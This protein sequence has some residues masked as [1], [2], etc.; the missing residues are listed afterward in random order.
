MTAILNLEAYCKLYLNVFVFLTIFTK[1]VLF[2]GILLCLIGLPY[3]NIHK[4]FPVIT[5]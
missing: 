5:I 4:R 1:F 3:C 2:T